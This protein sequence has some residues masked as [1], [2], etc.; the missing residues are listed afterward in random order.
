MTADQSATKKSWPLIAALV[1]GVVA[2]VAAIALVVTLLLTRGGGI[3]GG[4]PFD[5]AMDTMD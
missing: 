4:S 3:A 1:G 2:L 5:D